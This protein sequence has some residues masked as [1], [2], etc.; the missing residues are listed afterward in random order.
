MSVA[1]GRRPP[2]PV[3]G[4]CKWIVPLQEPYPG[5]LLINEALYTVCPT[6]ADGCLHGGEPPLGYR[7]FHQ[8]SGAVY[9]L[10][11]TAAPWTC[12]CPDY[13]R[14]RA[15]FDPGGCKHVKALQTALARL[16]QV[17]AALA[18]RRPVSRPAR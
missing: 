3:C 12:D 10:D 17:R 1:N 9:D 11:A 8:Q 16:A 7:L 14:N 4:T 6:G 13:E 15:G 5:V 2:A 18:Q